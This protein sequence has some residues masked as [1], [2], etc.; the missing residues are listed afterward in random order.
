MMKLREE[1]SGR[2]R[3]DG[4]DEKEKSRRR[5]YDVEVDLCS[6]GSLVCA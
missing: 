4:G 3:R 2:C 5:T 6:I 1:E